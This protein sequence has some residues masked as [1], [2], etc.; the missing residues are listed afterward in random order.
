MKVV[1]GAMISQESQTKD[2]R[3]CCSI[4]KQPIRRLQMALQYLEAANQKF[5]KYTDSTM[6][7]EDKRIDLFR[8]TPIRYLGYANEVGEAFRHRVPR[9]VVQLTYVI[10]SGYVL[11]D[12]ID[13]GYRV[14]QNDRTPFRVKH[15]VLAI[16]DTLLWQSFASVIIPGFTINRVCVVIQYAQKK[17]TNLAL[18]NHWVPTIIGLLSIPLVVRPIDYVVEETMNATYRKWFNY[19]PKSSNDETEDDE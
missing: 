12:V 17:T 4:N 11:G 1:D 18:K 6:V 13:K 16:A 14:F 19:Y 7:N 9:S 15:V 10:S 5:D 2:Y 3:W 8:D